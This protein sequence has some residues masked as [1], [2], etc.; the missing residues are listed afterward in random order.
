LR[1]FR[2]Q[3]RRAEDKKVKKWLEKTEKKS[4]KRKYDYSQEASHRKE[5]MKMGKK[6]AAAK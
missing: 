4:R 3:E 1:T 2:L 5:G 6:K